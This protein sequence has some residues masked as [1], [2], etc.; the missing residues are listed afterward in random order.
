MSVCIIGGVVQGEGKFFIC[1]Y[2][3]LFVIFFTRFPITRNL[4]IFFIRMKH[5]DKI[6]NIVDSSCKSEVQV[7]IVLS[8][9]GVIDAPRNV[10]SLEMF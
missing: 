1:V 10:Y 5:S 2:F 3:C 6:K 9:L 4:N 7:C 8:L